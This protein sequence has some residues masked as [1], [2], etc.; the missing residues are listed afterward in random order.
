MNT[1]FTKIYTC[2]LLLQNLWR[3]ISTSSWHG[4]AKHR[5]QLQGE[6]ALAEIIQS[7]WRD[8]LMTEKGWQPKLMEKEAAGL[9]FFALSIRFTNWMRF[10]D[11]L[12]T[13]KNKVPLEHLHHSQNKLHTTN[14]QPSHLWWCRNY[15]LTHTGTLL[16]SSQGKR[17]SNSLVK[18]LSSLISGIFIM[19]PSN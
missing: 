5:R 6:A 11:L 1:T 8:E 4:P 9:R 10:R 12:L 18:C 19:S 17:E 7:Q 16:K 13:T 3:S 2:I 14:T 15:Y